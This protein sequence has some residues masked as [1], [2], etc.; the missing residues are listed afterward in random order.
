MKKINSISD[1][2]DFMSAS[3]D[4]QIYDLVDSYSRNRSTPNDDIFKVVSCIPEL[5]HIHKRL[6]NEG[7]KFVSVLDPKVA[8]KGSSQKFIY[9]FLKSNLTK[10]LEDIKEDDFKTGVKKKKRK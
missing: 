3:P 6:K 7:Y 2:V 9:D 1:V 5:E 10:L 4:D 8:L